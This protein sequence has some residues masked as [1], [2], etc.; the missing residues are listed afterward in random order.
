MRHVVARGVD[1]GGLGH[2][3]ISVTWCYFN[4]RWPQKKTTCW[5]NEYAIAQRAYDFAKE[6]PSKYPLWKCGGPSHNCGLVD[7]HNKAGRTVRATVTGGT[8]KED[9]ATYPDEF[10]VV[11]ANGHADQPRARLQLDEVGA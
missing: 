4:D 2:V 9:T 7:M 10:C 11:I 5:V 6:D 3:P 8:G 1:D